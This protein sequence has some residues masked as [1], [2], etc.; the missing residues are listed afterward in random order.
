[1]Y[2]SDPLSQ[3]AC[4][5]AFLS[6]SCAAPTREIRAPVEKNYFAYGGHILFLLYSCIYICLLI[7]LWL[8]EIIYS[9]SALVFSFHTIKRMLN[10]FH[11]LGIHRIQDFFSYSWYSSNPGLRPGLPRGKE[12]VEMEGRAARRSRKGRL[13]AATLRTCKSISKSLPKFTW[14]ILCFA[15]F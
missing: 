12:G 9:S 3:W 5:A 1:M 11:T 10:F 13:T 8:F 7:P 15:N 2:P 4:A 6:L 14:Q